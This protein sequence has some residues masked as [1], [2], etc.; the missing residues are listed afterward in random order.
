[1]PTGSNAAAPVFAW[2]AVALVWL[3][4]LLGA[5][6]TAS[7]S[8]AGC[9]TAWPTCLGSWTPPPVLAGIVE[10]THR[11]GALVVTV[12]LALAATVTWRTGGRSGRRLA[13]VAGAVWAAQVALGALAVRA[14]LLPAV[15]AAHDVGAL[16]LLVVALAMALFLRPRPSAPPAE[17]P[18]GWLWAAAGAAAAALAV[19]S[20]TAHLEQACQGLAQCIA[21]LGITP[22]GVEPGFWHGLL[23]AVL[24][25]AVVQAWR[26]RQPGRPAWRRWLGAA[27]IALAVQVGLGAGLLGTGLDPVVLWLHEVVG[28]T[29]SAL[30]AAAALAAS[31]RP[32][33]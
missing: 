23:V 8:G 15:V 9:G 6:V 5:L 33:A 2:L 14:G 22:R 25:V 12:A 27:L 10:W 16:A 31:W 24:L 7:Q 1:M 32:S 28:T 19:G 4:I 20:Y 26:R 3:L 30:V 29:A 11:V 18:R 17:A 13:G 21:V